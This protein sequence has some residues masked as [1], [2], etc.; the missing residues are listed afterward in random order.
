MHAAGHGDGGEGRRAPGAGAAKAYRGSD[1]VRGPRLVGTVNSRMIR[2]G[3]KWLLLPRQYTLD[4][5]EGKKAGKGGVA[6]APEGVSCRQLMHF[7]QTSQACPT[8]KPQT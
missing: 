8:D 6:G 3:C 5:R 1:P 7:E 4:A 2:R